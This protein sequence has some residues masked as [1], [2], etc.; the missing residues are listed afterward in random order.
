MSR[1]ALTAL[2]Y[3]ATALGL[4]GIVVPG[5]PTVPFILL[6]AWAAAR[7]SPRLHD[8]LH[9]H[10]R[11]GPAL[12]QWQERRAVPRRAKILAIALMALSWGLLYWRV[13]DPLLIGGVAAL[14]V[15]V[16]TYVATRTEP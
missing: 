5:L 1:L 12:V 8:W 7:A 10:P 9:G 2:A 3:L 16:G 15:V 14:F 13:D 6:A 4:L 11:F